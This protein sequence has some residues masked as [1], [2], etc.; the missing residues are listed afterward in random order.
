[1]TLEDALQSRPFHIKTLDNRAININLDQM[2]TPD[3]VYE[4]EGEGMPDKKIQ[5]RNQR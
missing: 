4:I 5:P 1:M 3:L 2:I